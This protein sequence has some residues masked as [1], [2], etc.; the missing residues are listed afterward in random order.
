MDAQ[1]DPTNDRHTTDGR[2]PLPTLDS[3]WLATTKTTIRSGV[4][5]AAKLK[6]AA[7]GISEEDTDTT[8]TVY[9]STQ[10]AI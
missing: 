7:V 2:V 1:S 8:Y 9:Y 4:K 10:Q 3:P 5:M 6:L